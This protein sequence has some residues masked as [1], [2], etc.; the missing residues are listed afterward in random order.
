MARARRRRVAAAGLHAD[1]RVDRHPVPEHRQRLGAARQPHPRPGRRRRARRRRWRRARRRLPRAHRR[2]A[3]RSTATWA[4][5]GSRTSRRR[6]A[7]ARATATRPA[8]RSPTSTATA[9]SIWSLARDER[10]ERRLRERRQGQVHRAARP[11]PRRD[12]EGRH[13]ASRWPTSTAT[14]RS[15]STS[16]TTSRTTSTTASRRSSARSTR[17]CARPARTSTRS[18]RSIRG[19]YKLVMRPDM[20][21]LRMT[22]RGATDEFYLNEGGRFTRVPLTSDRFRDAARQAAHRGAGVVRAG[23][24]VRRPERRRRAGPL[25]RQRFRG[26]RPALVQRRPR[27]LSSRR[28]DGAAADQQ[29]GDGRR[30]RRRERRRPAR[31]VR[32][33]HAEP[34]TRIGSRRRSRRTPRCRSKP[35]DIEIAA[36]AAA[37]H[38]VH[39]PRRRH[40]RRGVAA[41]PACRRAGGR[42]PRCSWTSTSTGGRT[43]SS[44]TAICGTSWTPTRRSDCRTGSPTSTGGDCA[45]SSRRFRS[46]TSRSAIAAT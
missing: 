39:Q 8:P 32:G 43:F 20:G 45:G 35:G 29:L 15:I 31:P 21:G 4:A 33:R 37:Q 44:P 24:E 9:T 7:S 13:D 5:G 17:W 12:R 46:R 16:R 30:R 26:H 28:L 38:A 3:A 40:V 36:P 1:G 23:R 19:E 18:R 2:A 11:R 25:R 6:P 22:T 14:A 42:G 27:R 41:M 34:T 10:A